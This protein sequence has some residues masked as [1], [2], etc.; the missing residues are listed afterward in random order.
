MTDAAAA[1]AA[2]L[3]VDDDEDVLFTLEAVLSEAGH[4]VESAR[5][6]HEATVRLQDADRFD[7]IVSDIGMPGMD[8]LQLLQEVRARG[9]DLPVILMTGGPGIDTAIKAVELGALRY[10]LKPVE[11]SALRGAVETAAR[12]TRIGRWR[13]EAHE[14]M[15]RGGPAEDGS[16]L[17]RSFDAALGSLTLLGQP[18]F[19]AASGEQAALEVLV[20]SGAPG[21]E[22]P[23][24]LF[25]AGERLGRLQDV[26]RAIRALAADVALPEG[27][28]LFVN[29]HAADLLDEQL[30]DA[31]APLARRAG[32]VV[33]EVTERASLERISDLRGRIGRLRALG[34]RIAVDD[35]GAGYAGLTSFA[36]LEP[37]VVKLDMSIVRGIDAD[38]MKARLVRSMT[39]LCRELGIQVVAEGVETA[40][41]RDEVTRLGCDL[42]QGFLLGRPQP[43]PRS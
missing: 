26:G 7:V 31:A 1:G 5:D 34:Y 14:Y 18:L 38:A 20:R 30:Y 6:G 41:E 19:R 27:V 22:G 35:L 15:S 13:R 4:R 37:D 23:G 21:L 42:I 12:L 16:Q 3:L 11:S 24:A 32:Q 25:A 8:G 9:V 2:V 39:G 10:L 33:I 29:I 28:L 43:L 36:A 40:G 17:G